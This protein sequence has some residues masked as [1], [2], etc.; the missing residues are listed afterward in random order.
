MKT[1][2]TIGIIGLPNVGKSSVI[3]S[4]KR[5]KA[6]NVGSYPGITKSMQPIILDSKVK[7]L[8]SP[9]II[10]Q[11]NVDLN[12]LILRNCVPIENVTDGVSVINHMMKKVK[13][14][15]LSMQYKIPIC[16]STEMLLANI[17]RKRGILRKG[18][19]PN[20]EKAAKHLITD[21]TN[22][23]IK[24]YT[25]VPK[26]DPQV[27]LN[28]NGKAEIVSEFSE[29]FDID[30]LLNDA[31]GSTPAD[32]QNLME[33]VY[34]PVESEG[35]VQAV[36][37][38]VLEQETIVEV[39]NGD[40]LDDDATMESDDKV[41]QTKSVKFGRKIVKTYHDGNDE[42][43]F[44]DESDGENF[45]NSE[46]QVGNFNK[47]MKLK[48]KHMKK[49]KRRSAKIDKNLAE[50]ALNMMDIDDSKDKTESN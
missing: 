22:G 28:L 44:E 15:Q 31:D 45:D 8:D 42:M 24:Y 11:R 41:V 5:A 38:D 18:G 4:L 37:D 17:A 29:T 40:E 32:V 1:A 10:M 12:S 25:A 36:N 13:G 33:D 50:A 7:L 20:I 2:I 49:M 39:N 47:K 27:D 14:N 6:C 16:T 35:Q 23:V 34:V 48:L 3:N 19:V 46:G 21:W 30:A 43:E 26:V 9:G